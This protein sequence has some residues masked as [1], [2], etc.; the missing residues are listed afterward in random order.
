MLVDFS[1]RPGLKRLLRLTDSTSEKGFAGSIFRLRCVSVFFFFHRDAICWSCGCVA[2]HRSSFCC[3][4]KHLRRRFYHCCVI[5]RLSI[6]FDS[7]WFK[8]STNVMF[9]NKMHSDVLTPVAEKTAQSALVVIL[10]IVL[11]VD[12]VHQSL[13]SGHHSVT[14]LALLIGLCVFMSDWSRW[15]SL[16]FSWQFLTDSDAISFYVPAD[17]MTLE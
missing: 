15:K 8:F 2:F 1:A 12:M 16:N 11:C 7:I 13:V 6:N 4:R 9:L 5:L 17:F 3:G 14:I 10:E